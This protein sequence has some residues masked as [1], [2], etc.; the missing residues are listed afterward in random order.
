M[1]GLVLGLFQPSGGYVRN[2]MLEII[3]NNELNK[4]IKV[5]FNKNIYKNRIKETIFNP[6]TSIFKITP[7]NYSQDKA[8]VSSLNQNTII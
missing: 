8:I 6:K 2:R 3:K 5:E 7:T 1:P 4:I